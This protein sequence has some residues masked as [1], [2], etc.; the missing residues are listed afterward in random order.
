[1]YGILYDAPVCIC[2]SAPVFS[3][4]FSASDTGNLLAAEETSGVLE[5]S[6]SWS[7]GQSNN[8][9]IHASA[10]SMCASFSTNILI[11]AL[12]GKCEFCIL[13]AEMAANEQVRKC[14]NFV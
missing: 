14:S 11:T 8:N 4:G 2:S 6:W 9:Q 12:K 1:M 13:N 5:A 10:N 3:H 7:N